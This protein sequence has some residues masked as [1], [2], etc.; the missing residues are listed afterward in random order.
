MSKNITEQS[1][2][3]SNPTRFTSYDND[4]SPLH[5]SSSFIGLHIVLIVFP[6]LLAIMILTLIIIYGHENNM[7]RKYF[8]KFMDGLRRR[9]ESKIVLNQI[10]KQDKTEDEPLYHEF[11]GKSSND[12]NPSKLEWL[13]AWKHQ[14]RSNRKVTSLIS[15]VLDNN[16]GESGC[17]DGRESH[18]HHHHHYKGV[19]AV[20]TTMLK[21]LCKHSISRGQ[22][23][24]HTDEEFVQKIEEDNEIMSPK[25][26]QRDMTK[27]YSV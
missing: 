6:S 3:T 25:S 12:E 26:R 20:P 2:P 18:H 10:I 23:L 11:F 27:V 14:T 8:N 19:V 13:K 4:D 22:F 15:T 16:C 5:A 24:S 9:K 17:K 1:F 7:I 21:N